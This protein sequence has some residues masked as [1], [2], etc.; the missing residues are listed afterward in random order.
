MTFASRWFAVW[1]IA[2]PSLAN[3][4]ANQCRGD[5]NGDD[6]VTVDE[7]LVTVNNALTGCPPPSARFINRG[8][9][10]LSDTKAGLEWEVKANDASVHGV[11]KTFTWSA[12]SAGEQDGTAFSVFLATLNTAPCF[13]GHCDW[14]L[15]TAAELQTLI[16]HSRFAP[17]ADP[18]FNDCALDEC[19]STMCSCTN[20]DYYWATPGLADLPDSAWA[21][22]FNYGLINGFDK[23]LPLYV[24]AVRGGA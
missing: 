19:P 12:T 10:T 5:F 15:P 14:R 8:D 6:A 18:A 3:A 1:L 11:A 7:I 2:L 13:A 4:Q 20:F 17:A 9:G 24:R 22:D 23:T 21:V 16:D